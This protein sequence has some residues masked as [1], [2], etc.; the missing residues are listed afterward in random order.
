MAWWTIRTQKLLNVLCQF[1]VKHY[2]SKLI[3]YLLCIKIKYHSLTNI[4][5]YKIIS[6]FWYIKF[7]LDVLPWKFDTSCI[8]QIVDSLSAF[9]V[10]KAP[11]DKAIVSYGAAS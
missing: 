10:V 7:T 1:Y 8:W 6:L 3:I 2:T 5:V 4:S 11:A 9:H